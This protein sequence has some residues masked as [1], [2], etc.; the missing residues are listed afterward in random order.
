MCGRVLLI[1]AVVSLPLLAEETWS[2]VERIVAVGDVHGDYEQ[3][4]DLLRQAGVI[5][6]KD[7]WAGGK[8]HLVQTGDI[9]DRGPET[10]K[11][12]DLLMDLEKQ[13]KKDGGMV[14]PLIG[15]HEAMNMYGDLRYVT[16]EEFS[17]FEN[18]DSKGLRDYAYERHVE[19]VKA[20]PPSEGLPEFDD[21]YH[22][23]WD[24]EHPLG[25]FEHRNAFYPEGEYGKWIRRNKAVVKINDTIFLHGGIGPKYADWEIAAFNERIS[26]ELSDFSLVRGGVA[27]DRE[28]PLWYRGLARD[29]EETLADHVDALLAKHNAMRIVV[30]HTPTAGTVLPR[31]GGKVL[32]ID[33]GLAG[34]YGK[35]MA[36]LVIENGTPYTLHRGHRLELPK[37]AGN[38]ELHRYL[39]EAAELDPQ[40]SPLAATIQA[41]ESGLALE[42][43]GSDQ[44]K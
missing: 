3:F 29:P 8:T 15:N 19:S 24:E 28:G 4:T 26:A 11:I 12:L 30:G 39:A 43:V 38:D 27:I 33:V 34:A 36:C 37:D 7:K 42:A 6:K 2:G 25:Y 1:A 14:H 44:D 10:R 40:P 32:M 21:A 23:K 9:P 17:S 16:P 13:A 35:R 5:D 31:F 18:R 41:L 22:A 20:N